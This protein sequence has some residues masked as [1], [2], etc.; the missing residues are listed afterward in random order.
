MSAEIYVDT[1]WAERAIERLAAVQGK[2]VMDIHVQMF[3]EHIKRLQSAKV[4]MPKTQAQGRK[5]VR[6]DLAKIIFGYDP[7]RMSK[8]PDDQGYYHYTGRTGAVWKVESANRDP[9]GATLATFHDAQKNARGRVRQRS[10]SREHDGKRVLDKL[11]VRQSV[12][13]RYWSEQQKHVGRL[14]SGWNA[15]AIQLR[16]PPAAWIRKHGVSRGTFRHIHGA[17]V[18]HLEATNRVPY[19]ENRLRSYLAAMESIQVKRLRYILRGE[20]RKIAEQYNN[21]RAA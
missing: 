7:A 12:A 19:A 8:S 6:Y 13:R 20:M 5:S 21:E 11:H 4:P 10:R 3:R 18:G 2:S 15:A 16:V 9:S 14:K 1:T 17:D